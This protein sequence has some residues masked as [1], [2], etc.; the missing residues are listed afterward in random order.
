MSKKT[1]KSDKDI[2]EKRKLKKKLIK[3][4]KD[5]KNLKKKLIKARKKNKNLKRKLIKAR[6]IFGIKKDDWIKIIGV[7]SIIVLIVFIIAIGTEP[8]PQIVNSEAWTN[9]FGDTVKINVHIEN[10]ADKSQ[11]V[12]LKAKIWTNQGTNT[13]SKALIIPA[14]SLDEYTIYF[15]IDMDESVNKFDVWLE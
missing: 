8:D 9:S 15:D 4:R 6:K 11:S 13:N 14:N 12:M 2:N 10:E 1:E 3:S 7:I 5:N